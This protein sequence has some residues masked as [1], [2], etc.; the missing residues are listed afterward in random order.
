M[1]AAS[2][3]TP[4]AGE[5]TPSAGPPVADPAAEAPRA[6]SIFGRR[7][8][9]ARDL[10]DLSQEAL[11]ALAGIDEFSASARISQYETGKHLPH[12]DIARRLA[13]ALQ[14][15]AAFLYATDDETA[16]LLLDWHAA[17]PSRRQAARA[18]LKRRAAAVA[19]AE[20]CPRRVQNPA[21]RP[22]PAR[23]RRRRSGRRPRGAGAE[24]GTHVPSSRLVRHA[25]PGPAAVVARRRGLV[26]RARRRRRAHGRGAGR[27]GPGLPPRPARVVRVGLRAGHAGRAGR[28]RRPARALAPGLPALPGV[29]ARGA[30]AVRL[31]LPRHRPAGPQG[32]RGDRAVPGLHRRDGGGAA[33]GDTAGGAAGLGALSRPC[34]S[35]G[36]VSGSPRPRCR[37]RALG[38]HLDHHAAPDAPLL[39]VHCAAR[40]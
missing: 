36:P 4:A 2:P 37:R 1:E 12:F 6:P 39:D 23:G 8:R 3:A 26:R 10:R 38:G 33:R 40:G 5:P 34:P 13:E 7:L 16:E 9:Q 21:R 14:V 32:R 18:L 15:P 35:P 22:A 28:R 25:G 30:A 24:G 19:W 29:A 27:V 31:R 17:E 20:P 11:G